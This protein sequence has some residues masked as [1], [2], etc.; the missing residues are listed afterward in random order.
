MWSVLTL[1][2]FRSLTANDA[3]S[4]YRRDC[5]DG[6]SYSVTYQDAH[7]FKLNLT[8]TRLSS[9]L[10]IPSRPPNNKTACQYNTQSQLQVCLTICSGDFCNGPKY[11]LP[12]AM[13]VGGDTGGG[14]VM[15]MLLLL[16]LLLTSEL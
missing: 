12:K 3:R 5:F 10:P 2:V 16:L 15:W 9:I 14:V 8:G 6:H 1:Y 13:G 11:E 4:Q 7:V